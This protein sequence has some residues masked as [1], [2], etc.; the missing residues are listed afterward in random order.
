MVGFYG[1]GTDDGRENVRKQVATKSSGEQEQ[2]KGI[3]LLTPLCAGDGQ[4]LG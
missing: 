2:T 1:R 3:V 4:R